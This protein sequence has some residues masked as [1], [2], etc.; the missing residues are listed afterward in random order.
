MKSVFGGSESK[1]TAQSG[2]ALLPPE[3]Q[4]AFKSMASQASS[5]FPESGTAASMFTPTPLSEAEQS[6]ISNINAGSAPTAQSIQSDIAM[7]TNPFDQS[8]IDTINREAAGQ[9][10]QLRSM[11]TSAGQ[12]GSNRGVLGA[13]DIDLTRLNQIGTF[14][15]NQFNTALNN[16]LTTMPAARIA[17]TQNI[18]NTGDYLRNLQGQT[19]QA[20]YTALARFAGLLGALPQTGGSTQTQTSDT[21]GDAIG[22]IGRLAS[23]IGSL[24]SAFSDKRLKKDIVSIGQYNG[25]NIYSYEYI[26]GGGRQI[27]VMAQEVEKTNPSAVIEHPSGYKMVDYSQLFGV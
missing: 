7:Q 16:A 10:S 2:W 13:N 17:S 27:G 12:Y 6:A 25:H 9:G 11:L 24:W 3:I 4:N 26:W 14:K 19:T 1:S 20:P 22:G 21:S 23:G 18:L 5:M 15:Q 8:V